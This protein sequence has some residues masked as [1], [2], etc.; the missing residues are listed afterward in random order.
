[1]S[2]ITTLF[3][4]ALKI[5][6]EFEA[7]AMFLPVDDKVMNSPPEHREMLRMLF[8]ILSRAHHQGESVP[9]GTFLTVTNNVASN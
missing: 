4:F 9:L 7:T 8:P 1:M 5:F 6:S 3:S 2:Q